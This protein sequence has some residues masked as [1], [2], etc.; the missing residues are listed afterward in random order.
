MVSNIKQTKKVD[1][2]YDVIFVGAGLGSLSA[3]SMIA[4]KGKK[5]LVVDKHNIPGGY[6]TNFSRKDFDFDVSLHS[7]D[8]VVKGGDSYKVIELT[9]VADKVEF[10][11]HKTLY[12]FQQGD[13]DIK[14][15]H[16]DIED[17]KNQLFHYFPEEKDNI[18]RLFKEADKNYKD[19]CG[20]L[21]AKLPFWLRFLATP[22]FF[23]RILKYENDTVDSFFSRFTQNERLKAVLSAQWS[24]YG[25][26]AK[27][28]AFGYFSYPFIDYLRNGG[29]SIKGG[30]QKLSDA[31]VEVI[32]SNGGTVLLSSPVTDIIVNEKGRVEGIES[33]RSG[34][35]SADKVVCNISPHAVVSLVGKDKFK[36]RFHTKLEAQKMSISGFQ[37]YL[38]LDCSLADLGVKEDEYIRFFAPM[39]SQREQF[40]C[41]QKGEVFDGKTGWSINYFSNVD[42]T[43]C[44]PGKSSLGL[45]TLIGSIDWHSLS[46][47]EY[48]EKKQQL[49]Q[50]LIDKAAE[51]IPNLKD[52]IVVCEA[53]SP[54]TMTKFT[55]NP[56]GSIYGFEQNLKQSGLF[57]RF[58]QKYPIKGLYQVGAYTFPG[59]GFIGTMLSGKTLVDRYF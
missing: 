10:L 22:F 44:A 52:H 46:K 4:Q 15:K 26:P 49:T 30:S 38:G 32:E 57:R 13:I 50:M 47:M 23:K 36:P 20:F 40:E 12:H 7:F 24:Y 34:V 55:N 18:I 1:S 3:A 16:R 11:S 29:Y 6:A 48:R 54:R 58:P 5:V 56:G 17:Y 2:Q 45:F 28:L 8:G 39:L 59:A 41:L 25:L 42:D 35:V 31:L 37:V 51:Q 9:G 43:L 21:F 33:K 53:G 19:M 27:D 14:A